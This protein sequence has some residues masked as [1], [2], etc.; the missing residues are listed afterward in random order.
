MRTSIIILTLIILCGCGSKKQNTEVSE[1]DWNQATLAFR[2]LNEVLTTENGQTWK[3]SL[4]G[5]LMLVN[6]ESRVIIAN[7]K[8][9]ANELSKQGALY[10]GQLPE[11][12]N[13]AN[14]AFDWKGK[15]WTMVALPLPETKAERLS[16]LIHESFHRIQPIIGFDSVHE[17][18]SVHLDT[19]DGRIYLKLE[20]EA[21]K[22]A[23][24]T[25]Q[26]DMHIK[27]ALLFRQYRYN[28]FP[29][30]KKAE[31]SLEILE[32]LAEYTGSILS[33]RSDSNLKEHYVSQID[34]FYSLPTFV[35]S[36]AY[37][38]T[39]VYGYLMHQTDENWNL[40]ITKDTNLSE[41]MFAFFDVSQQTC[42]KEAI[43][44]LGADYGIDS[45]IDL[46]T[47]R[48]IKKELLKRSYRNTFLSDSVVEIGLE[49]MSIGFNPSNIMPL[50]SLGTVYPN[51]RITDN[52]GI[53]EVDSCGA[54]VSPS[55]D[56][57][58]I[59]Y[60]EIITDTLIVGRGWRLKLNNEWKLDKADIQ[61][62]MKKE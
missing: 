56:K 21:L 39:P 20:L 8:D 55:W 26:P 23:L 43:M 15:H 44:Q 5:P 45:I 29:E 4:Q 35:R 41:Y 37:F 9:T 3:Y 52:W 1:N 58:T 61:Y 54:L 36:F 18:P 59:S 16:L 2:E 53:L 49:K 34:W 14:T 57:V 47:Q 32:G 40:Q 42:T 60:P 22:R 28:L 51:L 17:V 48:E 33:Q 46:E 38:T 6:R 11:S 7:E 13:I 19:K 31:N 62:Q 10:V 30:A 24:T 27:N 12:I 50:D 25:N